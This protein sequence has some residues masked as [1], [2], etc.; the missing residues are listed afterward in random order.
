MYSLVWYHDAV[1]YIKH[2]NLSMNLGLNLNL[3][4]FGNFPIYFQSSIYILCDFIL[5]LK[6]LDDSM[7]EE[8]NWINNYVETSIDLRW[9]L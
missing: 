2:M 5:Y 9:Y 8:K 1:T 6:L 3:Y 7:F 4:H